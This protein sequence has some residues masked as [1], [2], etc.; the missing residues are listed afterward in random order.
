MKWLKA[1]IVGAL[2]SLIM[3]IIIILGTSSGFAPFN[4]PPSAARRESACPVT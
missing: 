2:G 3:Y 1:A 4:I